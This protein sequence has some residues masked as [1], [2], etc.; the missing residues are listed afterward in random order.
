MRQFF[1]SLAAVA[2]L[3]SYAGADTKVELTGANTKIEFT[4]TKADGKHDGGFKDVT[5]SASVGDGAESLKL[6]VE[7]DVA[8][9]YSDDDKLT[10]HLKSPDF[11]A[12]KKHPKATF[13][14]TKVAKA[15]KGYEVTG[16][17]TL[18]GKKKKVTFP[19]EIK[20]ADGVDLKADF[21]IKRS[22]WGMTYGKGKIDDEVSL[23]VAVTA[24][25]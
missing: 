14:V 12:V 7:I 16:D 1:V 2:V 19:A 8:S 3:A 25:K 15:D 11:F 6:K 5:G 4:G 17:L 24:K 18:L 22:D 23:K 10:G 20:V 9:M 13:E 21:K